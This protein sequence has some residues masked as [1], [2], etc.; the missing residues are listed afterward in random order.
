[1]AFCS[2]ARLMTMVSPPGCGDAVTAPT[3]M[4]SGDTY[5]VTVIG[6]VSAWGTWAYRLC[7]K[8]EPSSQFPSPGI[9]PRP[10]GDD[11]QFRFAKPLYVGKCN[12]KPVKTSYFQVNLGSGWFHPIANGDPSKPSSDR[13]PGNNQ[14]PYVFTMVGEGIAPQFRFID[15]HPSDNSGMFQITIAG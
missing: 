14:R 6:A 15:Y 8:P 1:M 4:T 11:A 2:G 13:N 3:A 10:A 5:A 7:G 9:A 12:R